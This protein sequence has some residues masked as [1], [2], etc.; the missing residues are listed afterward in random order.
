MAT[1][2]EK[3]VGMGDKDMVLREGPFIL[4]LIHDYDDCGE[5]LVVKTR[6]S[7]DN[8]P[9]ING[10]EGDEWAGEEGWQARC[11]GIYSGSFAEDSYLLFT[12]NNEALLKVEVLGVAYDVELSKLGRAG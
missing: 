1:I 8:E 9:S 3:L 6:G 12:T 11:W 2:A 5:G 4:T 10:A 7:F